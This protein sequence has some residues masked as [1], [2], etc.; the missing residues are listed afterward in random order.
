MITLY[1][2]GPAPGL[3]D[4]R[5][6]V[7]KAEI[8]HGQ[9]IGCHAPDDRESIAALATILGDKPYLMGEHPCGADATASAFSAHRLC[10]VFETP[11]KRIMSVHPVLVNDAGRM[12]QH[13]YPEFAS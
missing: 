11:L 2:F 5:P 6:F 13:W 7:M 1:T 8:L 12:M 10:Q 4:Q 3:P 9:G